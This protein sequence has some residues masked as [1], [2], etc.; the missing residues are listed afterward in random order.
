M[1]LCQ[2]FWCHRFERRGL[3]GQGAAATFMDPHKH[4]VWRV[5]RGS[6]HTIPHFGHCLP[7]FV[8]SVFHS[9]IWIF[10]IYLGQL[11]VHVAPLPDVSL[12][13]THVP[14]LCRTPC[15]KASRHPLGNCL[16]PSNLLQSRWVSWCQF[17][18]LEINNSHHHAMKS[19]VWVVGWLLL[20]RARVS[21]IFWA[22][23]TSPML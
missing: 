12:T 9:S 6:L 16:P 3:K 7:N 1:P 5:W 15:H 2:P 17:C 21:L 19:R 13:L 18:M 4:K 14:L 11:Q 20:V 10:S 23:P 8:A 22:W